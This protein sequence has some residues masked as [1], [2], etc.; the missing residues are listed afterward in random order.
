MIQKTFKRMFQSLGRPGRPASR[1]HVLNYFDTKA[2][3][4]LFF[5]PPPTCWF[6]LTSRR[7]LWL[8]RANILPLL[9]TKL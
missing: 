3:V 8:T 4:H 9:G 6:E 5:S 1:I 7:P 2:V